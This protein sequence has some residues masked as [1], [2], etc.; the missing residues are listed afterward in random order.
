M[1]HDTISGARPYS[2][3]IAAA[4][5]FAVS[6]AGAQ[7]QATLGLE[8]I[9]VTAQHVTENLQN[10]PV[11]IT[12]FNTGELAQRNITDLTKLTQ[13]VPNL[14]FLSST[15]AT[16]SSAAFAFIRGIGQTNPFLQNDPGVGI[17]VDGVYIG[18]TQGSVFDVVDLQRVE[19]L[20]GPQGTLYGR[21]TIG[22]AINL[23]SNVPDAKLALSGGVE[24]GNYGTINS[25]I[26]VNVPFTDKLFASLAISERKH[27]G[28]VKPIINANCATCTTEALTN[29]NNLAARLAIRYL[30]TDELTFDLTGDYSRKNNLPIGVRLLSYQVGLFA[31]PPPIP[32]GP[33]YDTVVADLHGGHPASFFVNGQYN[34]SQ[35]NFAGEDHQRVWGTALTATW[36]QNDVTV[37]S[38][39]AYRTVRVST[40]N[41]GDGSPV[42]LFANAYDNIKQDQTSQEFQILSSAFDKRLD[43]LAGVYGYKENATELEDFAIYQE[44]NGLFPGAFFGIPCFTWDPTKPPFNGGCGDN[45]TQYTNYAVV[46]GAAYANATYHITDALGLTAGVRYSYDKK[47]FYYTQVGQPT[48]FTD[49]SNSWNAFTPRV[50]L[51]YHVTNDAMLYASYA[52]GFKS[53]AFNNGNVVAPGGSRAV[54][55]EKVK[56]YEVGTK[57][58]WLE[59]RLTANVA[60]FYSDYTDQQLQVTPQNGQGQH[61]FV[62]A[63]GSHIY[64]AELEL[65]AQATQYLQFNASAGYTHTEITQVTPG[66]VGVNVGAKLPYT[67]NLTAAVGS[68]L[69]LPMG[70]VGDT[71]LRGDWA[72]IGPQNG[73]AIDTQALV[74]PGRAIANFRATFRPRD[75]HWDVYGYVDNA[76]N[77]EY[78]TATYSA[79]AAQF[80]VGIDGPPRTVG[81]GVNFH[82]D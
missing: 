80:T 35:S 15:G 52:Q 42:G 27:D 60:V 22:G 64:G 3:V 19:V 44:T 56:S 78:R 57:T 69:T 73:D 20:R 25:H 41:D 10:V 23:I 26:K 43:W 38:I 5:L 59:H 40:S 61:E 79:F 29:E 16:S 76:L 39:S 71:I 46:S 13:F 31:P 21:N 82:F 2:F 47:T 63:G 72:Y 14:N 24:G 17:Y 77:R 7:E 66:T 48:E 1:H 37:K 36:N 45:G 70:A 74:T 75:A 18:R 54:A 65:K 51:E 49:T 6:L 50:A 11:A 9:V 34:T 55:P 81:G 32:A 67:P 62:N 53:G 28:Y 30:A 58:E 12:A 4:M 68:Q 8:E 33:N